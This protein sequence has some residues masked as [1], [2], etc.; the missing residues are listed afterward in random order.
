MSSNQTLPEY[1]Q[2]VPSTRSRPALFCSLQRYETRNCV[3][4]KVFDKG[5]TTTTRTEERPACDQVPSFTSH[6]NAKHATASLLRVRRV[7]RAQESA[8]RSCDEF[9]ASQWCGVDVHIL[10]TGGLSGLL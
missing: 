6:G 5:F 1:M 2:Y 7:S 9:C 4:L 10:P 8:P 3:L